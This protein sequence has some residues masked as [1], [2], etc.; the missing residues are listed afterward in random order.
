MFITQI[1]VYLENSQGTLRTL[2]KTLGEHSVD[3]LAL[4]V[5]DTANFGII[6]IVVREGDVEKAISALRANGFVAKTNPVLCVAV[7]NAP[8]GLDG[9]LALIEAGNISISYMYSLNY[10]IE[11]QALMVLR[12]SAE[13]MEEEQ[14]AALLR[15]QGVKMVTQAEMN[16]L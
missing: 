4:S 14:I 9:V 2:T 7:P 12:L 13:N 8:A 5:A 1:S 11:G 15:E 10:N 3:M 6:R 16:G